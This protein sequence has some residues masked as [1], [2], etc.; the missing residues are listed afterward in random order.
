MSF[1]AYAYISDDCHE[2]GSCD[3]RIRCETLET[4]RV[5]SHAAGLTADHVTVTELIDDGCGNQLPGVSMSLEEWMADELRS[6]G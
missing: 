5:A 6:R 4:I 1:E 3:F 2:E